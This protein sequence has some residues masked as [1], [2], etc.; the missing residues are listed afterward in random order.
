M[1]SLK[2]LREWFLMDPEA[3]APVFKVADY[4]L[5]KY[6]G[7]PE[8]TVIPR[9]HI[10]ARP[11]VEAFSGD[12]LAYVKWLRKLVANNLERGSAA[13]VI[14]GSVAKDAQSRGINRRRRLL[15]TEAVRQALKKGAVK[16]TTLEKGRYK[17]RVSEW[18]KAYYK[19]FLDGHRKTT[20]NGRL[21]NEERDELITKFWDDLAQRFAS[22]DIPEA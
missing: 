20:H 8:L 10:Y 18:I 15:E 21:S 7:T 1:N 19:A 5:V 11:V 13:A 12:S 17:R 14:I 22:G 9:E 2:E 6:D 3:R 16:D 4:Y